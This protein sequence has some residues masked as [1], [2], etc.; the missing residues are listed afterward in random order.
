MALISSKL[1]SSRYQ[2]SNLIDKRLRSRSI[3]HSWPS[4]ILANFIRSFTERLQTSLIDKSHSR[5]I[6]VKFLQ[7]TVLLSFLQ[8]ED[9]NLIIGLLHLSLLFTK[10]TKRLHN[11]VFKWGTFAIGSTKYRWQYQGS[12]KACLTR[13]GSPSRKGSTRNKSRSVWRWLYLIV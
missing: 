12:L 11:S 7:Y 2:L 4:G 13:L 3:V 1:K 9:N 6:L 5:E 10:F 8:R